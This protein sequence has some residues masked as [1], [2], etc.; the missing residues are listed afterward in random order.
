MSESTNSGYN[1]QCLEGFEN[2]FD[3]DYMD[4]DYISSFNIP[5]AVET[6]DHLD[7]V[8]I[9]TPPSPNQSEY[10]ESDY[11][12]AMWSGSEAAAPTML[13]TA[14]APTMPPT[15]A[16]PTM[17]PTA[18]A[19]TMPPTTAPTAAA[20]TMP[21]TAAAPTMPPTAAAPTMP[22]TAAA[23]AMPP[24]TPPTAAAP[25]MPPSIPGPRNNVEYD[26]DDNMSHTDGSDPSSGEDSDVMRYQV[27]I[28][29]IR[30]VRR[31]RRHQGDYEGEEHDTD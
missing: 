24:T 15:A 3:N 8:A 17:P 14:A 28:G 4:D 7:T 12:G 23:P 18:A 19:P 9:A 29:I 5:V 11:G 16:A 25:T 20:P 1:E 26:S 21:P 6:F 13:P 22:P 10:G 31:E 2:E 27:S 30:I